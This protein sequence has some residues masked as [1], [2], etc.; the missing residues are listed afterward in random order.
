MDFHSMCNH[1][2]HL[3]SAPIVAVSKTDHLNAKKAIVFAAMIFFI[4]STTWSPSAF[5]DRHLG[6]AA[7]LQLLAGREFK[8][9][10]GDG[11][12]GVGKFD[13]LGSAWA[14]YKTSAG[15]LEIE[16]RVTARIRAQ[17]KELCFAINGLEIIAG[18]IC[19]P[20]LE[21][22]PGLYRLGTRDDWCDVKLKQ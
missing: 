7:A 19:V 8:F 4:G 6:G 17:D 2:V 18:E 11:M 15:D 10:C 1:L 22:R 9:I 21:K 14:V 20:V 12:H 16:Q 3:N 13:R 5:A